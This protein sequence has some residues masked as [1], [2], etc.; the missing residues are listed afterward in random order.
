MNVAE[1]ALPARAN[2]RDEVDLYLVIVGFAPP[3]PS[4]MRLYPTD[5]LRGYF[6]LQACEEGV[7]SVGEGGI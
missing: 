1:F 7:P 4:D 6:D 5:P 3:S 2:R